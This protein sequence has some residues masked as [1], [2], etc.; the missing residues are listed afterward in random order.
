MKR[1]PA[2]LLSFGLALTLAF[3]GAPASY[4]QSP[5]PPI[6]VETIPSDEPLAAETPAPAA[7]KV[8]PAAAPA[9]PKK[10]TGEVLPWANKPLVPV[11]AAPTGED[12]AMVDAAAAQCGTLF[13]AACRDLKTC[14]WIADVAHAD[15]TIVPAR[16]VARPPA[17]PKSVKKTAPVKKTAKA[18]AEAPAAATAPA[19][20]ASVTRIEDE[21]PVAKPEKRKAATE[22]AKPIAPPPQEEPAPA[23]EAKAPEPVEEAAPAAESKQAEKAEETE[24]V[25]E[26]KAPIVVKPPPAP[27][28]P[29]MPSFSSVSPIM[30]GGG[31]AVVVTVPPSE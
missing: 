17:P 16:C 28:K 29:Q 22:L 6:T 31:N 15:G 2:S 19:V 8:V 18:P 9:A 12:A 30:P 13:E 1:T 7:A 4:A 23:V 5:A 21:E 3:A 24:K 10:K 25:E 20:K 26:A 27:S 11:A 14:A